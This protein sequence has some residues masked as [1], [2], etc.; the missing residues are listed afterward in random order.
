MSGHTQL[1]ESLHAAGVRLTPQRLLILEIICTHDGHITAEK[2]LERVRRAYPYVEP[3]TVYRTLDLLEQRHLVSKID[4]G[5]G[6]AEYEL[7]TKGKHHHMVCRKC[8]RVD[9]V[10]HELLQP[11][12]QALGKQYRFQAD[13]DHFAIFGLCAKC[14]ISP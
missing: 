9:D 10:D 14:Q 4:L 12:Q 5:Q 7:L 2:I 13:M 8:G 3:S 6:H 1:V 11:L